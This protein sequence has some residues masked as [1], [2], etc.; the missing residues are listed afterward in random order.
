MQL[1]WWERTDDELGE[2]EEDVNY[3]QE[4]DACFPRHRGCMQAMEQKEGGGQP[5]RSASRPK[6]M[7][8]ASASRGPG[9]C[10]IAP[11]RQPPV[12]A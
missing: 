9:H 6:V 8:A 3:E 7:C 2:E 12:P 4:Y 10:V 5:L 11:I 1:G